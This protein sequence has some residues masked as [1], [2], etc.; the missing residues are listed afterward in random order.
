VL[1]FGMND[2]G[3]WGYKVQFGLIL[4]PT[5]YLMVSVEATENYDDSRVEWVEAVGKDSIIYSNS[6]Q[7]IN[8][9]QLRMNLTFSPELSLQM[10]L[11]PFRAEMEYFDFKRLTAPKTLDFEPY[12]Y[13]GDPDFKIRNSVGTFV[14]RW[15]YLPGSTLFIVYNLN[16]SNHFSSLDGSWDS[17]K[18]NALFIKLNYW[19][20]I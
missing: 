19:F 9:I 7:K 4:K 10:Y 1:G 12:E 15:E 17:Y 8:E 18:S 14:L 16:D 6:K 5:N 2:L 13:N 3:G 11:Q 20:Q